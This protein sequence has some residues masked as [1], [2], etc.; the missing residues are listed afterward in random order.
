ML[1]GF[2]TSHRTKLGNQRTDC[3]R[4]QAD[5][6]DHVPECFNV[7]LEQGVDAQR[8]VLTLMPP[9]ALMPPNG[10]RVPEKGWGERLKWERW[11]RPIWS[12]GGRCH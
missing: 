8:I 4:G 6:I 2:Q 12:V 5:S 1:L 10:Q 9:L 7:G 11:A 3:G